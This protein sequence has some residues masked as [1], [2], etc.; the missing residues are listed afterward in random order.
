MQIPDAVKQSVVLSGN[1]SNVN[2]EI[3]IKLLE[4]CFS[5]LLKGPEIHGMLLVCYK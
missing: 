5:V 1:S 4:N 2:D 3:Y